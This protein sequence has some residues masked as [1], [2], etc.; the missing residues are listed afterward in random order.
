MS[1]KQEVEY[2][3]GKIW[4]IVKIA[5]GLVRD[6]P[7]LAK[8][9]E[10]LKST[11]IANVPELQD[12][13]HCANCGRGMKIQIYRAD[14]HAALFLLAMARQVREN[15]HKGMT[16]TEANKVHVPSLP[17]T[18]AVSKHI[19]HCDY[20]GFVKQAPELKGTG[21]WS[22]TSWGWRALRGE[23]V[24]AYAKYWA[25]NMIGR[26]ETETVTLAGMFRVHKE[27]VEKAIARRKEVRSDHRGAFAD[28]NPAEWSE[29]AGYVK[30]EK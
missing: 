20:L 7:E 22:I 19:T 10:R 18:N 2:Q 17:V 23:A 6:N 3:K 30:I 29:I 11:L 21:Y 27:L 24:P 25:G 13:A 28:Y 16:F 4:P 8:D 9:E 1:K 5:L 14:L 26:A 15:L 12:R